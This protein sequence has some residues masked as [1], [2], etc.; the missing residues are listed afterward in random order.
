MQATEITYLQTLL[1]IMWVGLRLKG[2]PPKTSP[3]KTP[4]TARD[5]AADKA[6]E[7]RQE[8]HLARVA[9]LRKYS[10]TYQQQAG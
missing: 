9:Q 10:P 2:D 4:K 1:R 8:T 5:H 7:G 6:A 3:V